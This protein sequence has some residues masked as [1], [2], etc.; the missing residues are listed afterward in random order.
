MKHLARNLKDRP[1]IGGAPV[2]ALPLVPAAQYV[3]MSDEAQQY[4]PDNQKSAI[5]EYASRHGFKIVKTYADLGKTGVVAKQR[6][7]LTE[8][9]TDVAS[10]N[11]DY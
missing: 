5:G 8:L 1:S 9:L 4:S 3:R 7:A 6:K 2:P 10:G 11:A